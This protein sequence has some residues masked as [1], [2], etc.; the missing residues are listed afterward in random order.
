MSD[1]KRSHNTQI[2]VA[3]IGVVGILGGAA[4]ANWDKIFPP[5][6]PSPGPEGVIAVPE[7]RADAEPER[8]TEQDSESEPMPAP[9]RATPPAP[10]LTT[11]D[12][13]TLAEEMTA[14]WWTA[15]EQRDIDALMALSGTPFYFD[16]G[17]IMSPAEI[18]A[19]YTEAMQ[20]GPAES[21]HFD[22]IKASE[23][24]ELKQQGLL[25]GRDR[26]LSNM[27]INDDDIAVILMIQGEGVIYFFRRSGSTLKM[28]GFWD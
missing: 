25:D 1:E 22:S 6:T 10:E 11:D 23:V 21:M 9:E 27:R 3:I 19:K 26:I 28:A 20:D 14:K 13:L 4:I 5:A 16:Q 2:T 18:R 8:D 17:V 15:W 12:A 7:E 24:G